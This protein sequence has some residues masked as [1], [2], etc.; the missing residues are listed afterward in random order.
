M[1]LSSKPTLHRLF[2][3]LEEFSLASWL[4]VKLGQWRDNE[5]QWKDNGRTMKEERAFLLVPGYVLLFWLLQQDAAQDTLWAA[6]AGTLED[7]IPADGFSTN[8]S[9]WCLLRDG[10]PT[11]EDRVFTA[12]LQGLHHPV[13]HGCG[14]SSEVCISWA[15]K[16]RVGS[17]KCVSSL[18]APPQP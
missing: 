15:G 9:A 16:R 1:L 8:S 7:N 13:G 10:F 17:S 4:D 3:I 14:V 11:P 6:Y 18:D 2:V 12:L 5:S